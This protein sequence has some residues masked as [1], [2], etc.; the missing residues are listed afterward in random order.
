MPLPEIDII[1]VNQVKWNNLGAPGNFLVNDLRTP[2][3][4]PN[5]LPSNQGHLTK[6]RLTLKTIRKLVAIVNVVGHGRIMVGIAA[7]L[8]SSLHQVIFELKHT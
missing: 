2:R 5:P 7:G 1:N 8:G 3:K 4:F 6:G